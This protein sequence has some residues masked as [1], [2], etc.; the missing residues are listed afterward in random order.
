MR[1][2]T[3]VQTVV[4]EN[5]VLQDCGVA[6]WWQLLEKLQAG[7]AGSDGG[8]LRSAGTRQSC[9]QLSLVDRSDAFHRLRLLQRFGSENKWQG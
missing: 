1:L 3:V 2:A 8:G 4:L 5:D 7:Q 6:A 9:R